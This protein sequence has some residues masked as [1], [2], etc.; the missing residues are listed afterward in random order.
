MRG[1]DKVAFNSTP[2]RHQSNP[3][4]FDSD[5]VTDV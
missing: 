1:V 4:I 5:S 3:F 2:L